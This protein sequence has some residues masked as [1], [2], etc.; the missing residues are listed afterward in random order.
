MR[1]VGDIRKLAGKL[2]KA[3]KG[4]PGVRVDVESPRE[5]YFQTLLSRG[6]R[7]LASILVA[8]SE[9]DGDWW[10]VV[11]QWKRGDLEVAAGFPS[12]D[13][14]V[15]RAYGEEEVFPWGLH[16]S[17]DQSLLPM[18]RTPQSDGREA[19]RAVRYLDLPFV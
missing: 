7:R 8:I 11:R 1:S 9:A 4:I 18:G 15:H 12:P 2:R 17:S 19:N 14:Y 3:A 16:R 10:G 5:A 6:D 13:D